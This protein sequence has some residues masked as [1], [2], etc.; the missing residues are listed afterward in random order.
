MKAGFTNYER[1]REHQQHLSDGAEGRRVLSLGCRR[2]I[3]SLSFLHQDFSTMEDPCVP[4]PIYVRL[5]RYIFWNSPH[6]I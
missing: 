4:Q 6:I 3:A 1:A 5:C 2:R